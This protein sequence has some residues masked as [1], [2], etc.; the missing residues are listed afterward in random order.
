MQTHR[1][2][3]EKRNEKSF[4]YCDR[5]NSRLAHFYCDLGLVGWLVVLGGLHGNR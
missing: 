3:D 4:V 1:F 2:G 5:G